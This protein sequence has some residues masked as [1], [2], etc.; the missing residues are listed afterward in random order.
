MV[1][2]LC[3]VGVFLFLFHG[4]SK[5][6]NRLLNVAGVAVILVAWIPMFVSE[7]LHRGLAIVFFLLIGI[8]AIHFS[9]GGIDKIPHA[10]AKRAF[11]TAYN[12]AGAAMIVLPLTVAALQFT[13][14]GQFEH[15]MFWIECFAIWSFAA[16]WLT[17]TLEYHLL[18]RIRWFG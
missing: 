9:K 14:W 6:E 7:L 15:Y 16:Y 3:A 18:L 12:V 5:N 1:G 10:R 17:K 2:M 13:P 11:K 8:V 4:L